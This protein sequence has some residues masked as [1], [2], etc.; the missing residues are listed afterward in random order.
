MGELNT[1]FILTGDDIDNISFLDLGNDDIT[2]QEKEN[3]EDNNEEPKTTEEE[4]S[5]SVNP[6][7][8][9]SEDENKDR[10][11][12][13]PSNKGGSSQ[14]FFSS[15]AKALQEE[16]VFSDLDDEALSKINEAEDFKNLIESQIR[17]GL[18]ERQKRI[19]DALSANIEPTEV[20]KYENICNYLDSI[21]EEAITKEGEEGET[22]RKNLIYQDFI[23]RGYSKERAE[24]EVKKSFSSGSDIEDAKDALKGN[25]DYF[26]GKYDTLIKEA[27]EKQENELNEKKAQMEKLKDDI[28]K[29]EKFIGDLT[30]DNKTRQSIY[31]NIA[32]PVYKDPDTGEYLTVIQKYERENKS[33]FLKNLGLVFTLTNGFKNL[34]GLVKNKVSK[35]VKKGLKNLESVINSTSRNSDGNLNFVSGVNEDPEAF[36]LDDFKLDI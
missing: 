31:N 21:T 27:K 9:G 33:E 29:S 35:E 26:N 19:D 6:E 28:L 25:T 5:K 10:Q 14:N 32:K 16:G 2:T 8:V 4:D 18:D 22:L 17:A 12:D 20:K 34:D 13:T 15:I 24:R 1:D 36:I 30:I 3:P 7:S 23:N 11:E